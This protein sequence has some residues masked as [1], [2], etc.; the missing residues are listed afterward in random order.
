[1]ILLPGT[2][3]GFVKNGCHNH[4]ILAESNKKNALDAQLKHSGM[5]FT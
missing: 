5:T 1:M 4:M 3:Y 2:S